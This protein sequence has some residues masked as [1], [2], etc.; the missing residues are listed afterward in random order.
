MPGQ[1]AS[2][3]RA[4]GRAGGPGALA[5]YAA[6]AAAA[7]G[8]LAAAHAPAR[9][10]AFGHSG[11]GLA[12]LAAEQARPG[13]WAALFLWEPVVLG[14]G[15][16]AD[17]LAAGAR[18]RRRAWP[19]RAAAAA[20]LG[21]KPPFATFAPA[22]L[23]AY[24]E[25]CMV[26]APPAGASAAGPPSPPPHPPGT[27]ITLACTPEDEAAVFESAAGLARAAADRLGE[28]A[29]PVMVAAGGADG[30]GAGAGAGAA[31]LA[32]GAPRTAAG[33]RAGKLQTWGGLRHLGPMEAPA[34][35]G[36]RVCAVLLAATGRAGGWG[37]LPGREGVVAGPE[38]GQE[39]GEPP[40]GGGAL[41]RM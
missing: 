25:A 1:G 32:A 29:C 26:P 5:A 22:S 33:L 8:L 30:A 6:A 27:T 39:E 36:R 17:G 7:A 15:A 24:V 38:R 19:T 9:P 37:R 41:S 13:A 34:A 4:P 11:G 2:P 12:A 23:A 10:V 16:P 31:P 14:A 3:P 20:A 21:G 40:G 18:R 35:V 28:V